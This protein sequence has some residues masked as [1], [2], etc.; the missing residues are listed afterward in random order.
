MVLSIVMALVLPLA[1]PLR[2]PAQRG[3]QEPSE[4][5]DMPMSTAVREAFGHP[6]FWLLNLGF[7]A[8]GFQLAFIAT[9]L[10]AYLLDNGMRPSDGVAALA[11]IAL[12]N[13][14]GIYWCGVL[15]GLYRRKY[16]LAGLYLARTTAMALFVLLPISTWNVYPFAAAM[17]FLWLGAVP[18]TT[19]LLS[20]VFG[21]RY[22]ST[23]FGF[24][25]LGHQLGS[26]LG[27]WLG[28]Y[29]F[30]L[31]SSY[32]P[33]WLG[34]MALGVLSALLHWPIDDRELLRPLP[35]LARV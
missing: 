35:A 6:G 23:L 17:G 21:V 13:I 26:F 4:A 32:E 12:T 28:G 2:E 33:I 25:F 20:Q 34:A 11:I 14:V 16:L 3:H 27:V 15:G 19:G 22:L 7:L 31:T 5:V 18:L 24:V 29:V 30:D 10:P 9:H 8:C 1:F